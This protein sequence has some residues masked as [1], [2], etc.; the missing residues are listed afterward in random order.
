MVFAYNGMSS[1]MHG[2][3]FLFFLCDSLGL[4]SAAS[5]KIIQYFV[6]NR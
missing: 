5:N 3:D 1:L 2:N 4:V 6:C